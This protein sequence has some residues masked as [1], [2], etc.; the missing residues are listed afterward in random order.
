MSR[1]KAKVK[2]PDPMDLSDRLAEA[3]F[4]LAVVA[5]STEG[6]SRG[7]RHS[8]DRDQLEGMHA[9]LNAVVDELR[10]IGQAIYPSQQ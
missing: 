4:K 7:V 10:A 3:R 9:I 6:L 8:D 5:L 2:S 1:A